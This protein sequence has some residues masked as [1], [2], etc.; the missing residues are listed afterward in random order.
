MLT[1]PQEICLFGFFISSF[2]VLVAPSINTPGS[3]NDFMILMISFITLFKMNKVNVFSALT[4]PV[5]L[6][7]ISSLFIAF[8]VK[9]LTNP[10]KLFLVKLI[11]TFVGDFFL[12]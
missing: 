12:N 2:T 7:V 9:L 3:F 8:Q 6:I 10:G 1:K 5:P 11:V 4:A